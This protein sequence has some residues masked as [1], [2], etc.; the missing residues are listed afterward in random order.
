M[1]VNGIMQRAHPN[2]LEIFCREKREMHSGLLCS[3]RELLVLI[4]LIGLAMNGS[5]GWHNSG[6]ILQAIRG[7]NSVK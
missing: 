2:I 3:Q 7:L 4:T 5:R 1:C 6:D